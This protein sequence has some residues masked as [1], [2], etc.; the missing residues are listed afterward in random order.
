[1]SD[2][3]TLPISS[4]LSYQIDVRVGEINFKTNLNITKKEY[5]E[6]LFHIAMGS[7]DIDDDVI[8]YIIQDADEAKE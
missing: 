3:K 2:K 5:V 8:S 1:M 4:G 6:T 7:P